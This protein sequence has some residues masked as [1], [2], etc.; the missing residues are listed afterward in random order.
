MTSAWIAAGNSVAVPLILAR[1]IFPRM[2]RRSMLWWPFA[3]A[4]AILSTRLRSG[5]DLFGTL[6]MSM[7]IPAFA[8]VDKN[9][10]QSSQ[11][12]IGRPAAVRHLAFCQN[13]A[14]D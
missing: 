1:P 14:D 13:A 3:A 6:T 4:F 5:V 2:S 10:F 12:S 11:L 8:L 7:R 9:D